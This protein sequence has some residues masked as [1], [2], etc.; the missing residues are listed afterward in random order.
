MGGPK[1]ET[2]QSM[3]FHFLSTD[4]QKLTM[5]PVINLASKP[6]HSTYEQYCSLT[7][8]GAFQHL[9]KSAKESEM[10]GKLKKF[11][12]LISHVPIAAS[13]IYVYKILIV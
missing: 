12:A 4:N 8:Y 3:C 2:T 6:I 9:T 1:V 10:T 13:L 7:S 5:P 11:T